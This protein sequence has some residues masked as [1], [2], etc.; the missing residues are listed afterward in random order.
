MRFPTNVACVTSKAS[1]QPAHMHSLIRAFASRLNILYMTVEL[2]TEHHLEFLSLKSESTLVKC[3]NVG[4]HMLRLIYP[5]FVLKILSYV[6]QWSQHK[7]K[8]LLQ[9]LLLYFLAYHG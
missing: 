3:H 6:G 4:N 5:C 2:L 9:G 8:H 7:K 1:C